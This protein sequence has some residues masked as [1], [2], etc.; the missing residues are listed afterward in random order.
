MAWV[1]VVAPP[2]VISC[3]TLQNNDLPMHLAVGN[4][5]LDHREVPDRDP[6][7]ANGSNQTWVPHEWLAAVGGDFPA[8]E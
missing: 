2:V 7:S 8:P 4:W 3:H 1:L 6:F 5:I